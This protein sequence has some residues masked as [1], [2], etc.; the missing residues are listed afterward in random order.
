MSLC[1]SKLL[2]SIEIRIACERKWATLHYQFSATHQENFHFLIFFLLFLDLI[3]EGFL[4]P[5]SKPVGG[6]DL[7]DDAASVA[8]TVIKKVSCLL[9]F[10]YFQ[11]I[12]YPNDTVLFCYFELISNL[13]Y[14]F[15]MIVQHDPKNIF[16]IFYLRCHIVMK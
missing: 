12:S 13:L 5:L 9:V 14:S 4:E 7:N 6:D 2:E 10:S 1:C 8:S 15:Y 11:L 16:F 3:K